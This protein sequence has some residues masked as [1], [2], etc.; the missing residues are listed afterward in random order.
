MVATY[1]QR[2]VANRILRRTSRKGGLDLLK[3]RMFPQQVTLPLRRQGLD[4]LPALGEVRETDPVHKL[5]TVFGITVWMVTGHAE[6]KAV[7]A[8]TTNFSND[9]RP[10]VGSDPNKP[11]EGIGGPGFT[12]PPDH[13]RLRKLLT[14]EFTKRKLARLAPALVKIVNDQLDPPEAQGP[15]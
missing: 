15:V 2:W 4:P 1:L 14:P 13:T 7:L 12:D 5:A 6:A 11:S 9:I 10:L 8:D 3:M